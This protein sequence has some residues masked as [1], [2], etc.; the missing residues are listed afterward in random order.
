MYCQS[1]RD[2]LGSTIPQWTR[3][4]QI[5]TMAA[6]LVEAG[7]VLN[8]AVSQ[9]E[10]YERAIARLSAIYNVTPRALRVMQPVG[11]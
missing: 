6:A 2:K 5:S 3:A 11:A 1:C 8:E 9:G 4:D 7:D 10:A